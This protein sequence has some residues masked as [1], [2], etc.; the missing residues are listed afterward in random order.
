M[1]DVVEFIVESYVNYKMFV[2]CLR[3]V[4]WMY[5]FRLEGDSENSDDWD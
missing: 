2:F 4:K 1:N 5:F 3:I